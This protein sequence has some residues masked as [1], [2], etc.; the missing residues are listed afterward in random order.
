MA[1]TPRDPLAEHPLGGEALRR[2]TRGK[3]LSLFPDLGEALYR[4]YP[5]P[6]R[7]WVDGPADHNTLDYDPSLPRW[8][9]MLGFL[10]APAVT[11][12]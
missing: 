4:D 1:D 2:P 7:L 6:K 5:G 8:A 9:E 12:R 3:T 11:D 10:L